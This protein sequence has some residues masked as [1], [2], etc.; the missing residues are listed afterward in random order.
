MRNVYKNIDHSLK[1]V[2]QTLAIDRMK[3]WTASE[4]Y[5]DSEKAFNEMVKREKEKRAYKR[6]LRS[7]E[8]NKNIEN[9]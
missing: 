2:K 9:G 8:E 6:Y 4:L 3:K 1:A 7:L 5:E